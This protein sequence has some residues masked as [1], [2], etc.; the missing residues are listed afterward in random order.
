MTA[1]EPDPVSDGRRFR[2]LDDPETLLL[3]VQNLEEGIYITNAEGDI[4]DANPDIKTI[5]DALARPDLFPDPEN[6]GKGAVHA[7][8]W[9][10]AFAAR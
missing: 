9:C 1:S 2:S 8:G 10:A 3:I 4:I 5:D 6:A 7:K